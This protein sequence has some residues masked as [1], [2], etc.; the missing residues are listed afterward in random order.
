MNYIEDAGRELTKS[1]TD[2]GE[3]EK[4]V[5]AVDSNELV[6]KAIPIRRGGLVCSS[7]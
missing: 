5:G 1:L 6:G 3:S 7:T 2:P 4:L